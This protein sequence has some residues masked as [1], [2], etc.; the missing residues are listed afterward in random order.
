MG[1]VDLADQKRNCYRFNHWL[2]NRKWWWSIFLWAIG[3]ASTNGHI[4]YEMMYEKEKAKKK[5][6]MPKKWTHMEFL[7]GLVYD[8][9]GWDPTMMD[10]AA[11]DDNEESS[12]TTGTTRRGSVFSMQSSNS[13]ANDVEAFYDFTCEE[14]RDEYFATNKPLNITKTRMNNGYFSKRWDGKYHP[15][16]PTSLP[17]AYCQYCRYRYQ[18]HHNALEKKHTKWMFNN[19]ARISRCLTCN[20]NLCWSCKL[21]W[22]GVK[23]E[24]LSKQMTKRIDG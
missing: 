4:V 24:G 6:S 2:R 18:H 23:L 13:N 1:S 16:L 12:I 21:E 14:G 9:L 5:G 19:R 8:L 20:V 17:S 10:D 15:D 11:T 7:E 22:H 3:V